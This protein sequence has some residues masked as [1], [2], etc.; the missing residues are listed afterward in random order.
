VRFA[1]LLGLGLLIFLAAWAAGYGLLPEGAL[2]GRSAAAALAGATVAPSFWAEWGRLLAVNLLMS[3]LIVVFSSLLRLHGY[4]LGYL[5]PLVWFLTYGLS[6]G[7]NSFSIPLPQRMAPSLAVLGR[8]GLYELAAYTLVAAA[9][10]GLPRFELRRL[11]VTVP[12]PV[13]A[14][15]AGAGVTPVG[16]RTTSFALAARLRPDDHGQITGGQRHHPGR[17]RAP[18]MVHSR[19]RGHGSSGHGFLLRASS[20]AM[21][22]AS[23]MARTTT[24]GCSTGTA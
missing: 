20:P 5:I 19:R 7:T 21:V 23:R 6:L 9:T 8:S 24:P 2:R 18:G 12:E 15:R 1:A 3:M 10:A 17:Q 4:P 22:S 14:G 11:F 16:A 13:R